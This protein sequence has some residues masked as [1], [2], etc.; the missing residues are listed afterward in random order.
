MCFVVQGEVDQEP[1]CFHRIPAKDVIDQGFEDVKPEW[2]MLKEDKVKA[3]LPMLCNRPFLAYL[4]YL[5]SRTLCVSPKIF[6]L[7][8]ETCGGP[9]KQAVRPELAMF[10]EIRSTIQGV[11]QHY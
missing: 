4:V 9:R 1:I 8:H 11:H 6:A 7:P 2:I 10:I 3:S 5:L